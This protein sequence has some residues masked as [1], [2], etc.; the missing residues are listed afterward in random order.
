MLSIKTLLTVTA[1]AALVLPGAAL[2]DAPDAKSPS[3][4]KQCK[5]LRAQMGASAFRD[6]YGTNKNK[7]NAFG[8]CVS[9]MSKARKAERGAAVDACRTERSADEAAFAAKFGTGK[10][11]RNAFGKCVSAQT[12]DDDADV[13]RDQRSAAKGCKTERSAGRDAFAEKYG[14]N[15]NKRNAFGKCVSAAAK[16][17]AEDRQDDAEAEASETDGDDAAPATPQND[18]NPGQSKKPS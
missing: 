12:K 16:E 13:R 14:T 9:Q 4:A 6:A 15:K 1:T 3:S 18:D 10:K 8:K 17:R 7:R 2:A 11:Q 5:T